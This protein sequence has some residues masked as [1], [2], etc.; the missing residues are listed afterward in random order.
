MPANVTL[1]S[2]KKVWWLCR[3]VKEHEWQATIKD[4]TDGSGCPFCNTAGGRR[5]TDENRLSIQYP[6]IAA[7]WHPTKNR[8]LW[9]SGKEGSWYKSIR[10]QLPQA[11]LPLKN[12]RLR[13]S[14]VSSG[15]N[16]YVWWQCRKKHVWYATI[17]S[18]ALKGTGCPECAQEKALDKS[19]LAKFP[20]AANQ[21]HPTRN[22]PLLPSQVAAGSSKR[23]YWRCF[24][25]AGHVWQAQVLQIVRAWKKGSNPCPH[26][27]GRKLPSK[28]GFAANHPDVAKQWH[29]Q[30]NLPREP[31]QVTSGSRLK[32]WWQCPK[33]PEHV[34]EATVPKVIES[35]KNG[36][37]G[38]P[39]C[40]GRRKLDD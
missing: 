9:G 24:K 39:F 33:S 26:C 6:K 28:I 8:M 2:E 16:E 29:R 7:E 19:L 12:R 22:L 20:G 13:P 36:N 3:R 18:R 17:S 23:L 34:W 14:D 32:C 15:S 11:E 30:M 31:Q 1:K 25:N 35:H 5:V 37:T 10:T 21:W 4:R 27:A 38:C 40:S